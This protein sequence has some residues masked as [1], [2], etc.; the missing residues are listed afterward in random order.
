MA[1]KFSHQK[2][3]AVERKEPGLSWRQNEEQVLPENRLG[4]V[5]FA[6]VCTMFLG[7]L[8]QVS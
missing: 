3:D 7:T 1:S 2:E 5:S 4:I 6:L 8:D